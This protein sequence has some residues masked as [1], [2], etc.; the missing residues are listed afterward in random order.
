MRRGGAGK[1]L[2]L[3]FSGQCAVFHCQHYRHD[4]YNQHLT[5]QPRH[6]SFVPLRTHHDTFPIMLRYRTATLEFVAVL[7][8]L[9][10]GNPLRPR[11]RQHR[12][13]H[14]PVMR[15]PV[16]MKSRSRCTRPGVPR[17]LP[18]VRLYREPFEMHIE[19]RKAL[20]Q[21]PLCVFGLLSQERL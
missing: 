17:R 15:R 4:N 7:A 6:L 8:L 18:K 9:K 2:L 13:R 1:Y 12:Q 16:C 20:R 5:H 14:S 10:T 3:Q 21:M 19:R 11:A